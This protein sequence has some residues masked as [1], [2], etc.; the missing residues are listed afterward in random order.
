MID[1]RPYGSLGQ[2]SNDWLNARYHF[3]FS[4]Y[5]DPNRAGVSVLKVINDDVVSPSGG[6]DMHPHRDMEIITYVR[7]GAISHEDNL[8]NQGRTEAGD[9]Q[10]MSA[11]SG[12]VHAEYNREAEAT[13]LYQ[14]W[15]E[16][17]EKGVAPRWE[18][19]AF[20]K[21][22]SQNGLTLLVS[23]NQEDTKNG[24]LY[25]HQDAAI[26]GGRM[27]PGTVVSHEM[28]GQGYLLLANGNITIDGKSMKAGDGAAITMRQRLP[29]E[30][31]EESE[32]LVID[33]F[34]EEGN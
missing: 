9:V 4:G 22:V 19:R 25:I 11:G 20:P 29:I 1:I 12:I 7:S 26:Y 2:F 6:F 16:P 32:L 8:G 27:A 5:Q 28:R 13:N 30:A 17:R 33:V 10:V 21:T 18:Q 23:G 31:N 34:P 3:S 14:I 24:V 15:I